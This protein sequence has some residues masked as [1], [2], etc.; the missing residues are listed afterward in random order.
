MAR[1]PGEIAHGLGAAAPAPLDE[2]D[3]E[4]AQSGHGLWTVPGAAAVLVEAPV[5]DVVSCLDRPVPAIEGEQSL[6]GCGLRGQ[7]GE[8]IGGLAAALAG[9]DLDGLAAPGEDLC[10]VGAVHV[11]VEFARR[12]DAAPLTAPVLGLGG[13]D[14]EVRGRRAMHSSRVRRISSRSVG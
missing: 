5:E 11:V 7:A 2:A 6:R 4:A 9:L 3:G 13:L 12:P 14:G 1:V 8:P 10:D